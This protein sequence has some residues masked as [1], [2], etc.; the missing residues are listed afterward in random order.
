MPIEEVPKAGWSYVPDRQLRILVADDD[1]IL[2]E[3]A[4][5][6][7]S[8][9]MTEIVTAA[10]GVEAL[11]QLRSA[12]FDLAVLDIHMPEMNGFALLQGIRRDAALGG[13]PVVMLTGHG[14]ITSIDRAFT[15]G[16]NGFASKPVDWQL[17]S[18][19]IKY[20]LRACAP[21]LDARNAGSHPRL[22]DAVRD[23]LRTAEAC[24]D[25]PNAAAAVERVCLQYIAKLAT[26]A[27]GPRAS[28][29]PTFPQSVDA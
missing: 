18:Y 6:H 22:E 5:V 26:D 29:A 7:L 8:A 19:Q 20:M 24:L 9:P 23:I 28:G 15:L 12:H 13:L 25:S 10:D 27:V 4:S 3:F 14:D 1:P 16:A 2:L 17:L 11:V 21:E